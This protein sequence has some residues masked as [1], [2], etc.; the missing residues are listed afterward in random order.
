MP[1]RNK[2]ISLFTLSCLLA[3]SSAVAQKK[4]IDSLRNL[5]DERKED[6]LQAKVLIKLSGAYTYVDTEEAKIFAEKALNLSQKLQYQAGIANAYRSIGT[7]YGETSNFDQ[8][9]KNYLQGLKVAENTQDPRIKA[10]IYN[11]MGTVYSRLDDFPQAKSYYQKALNI[12]QKIDD[13]N[14]I[15]TLFNNL[16][17]VYNSEYN[18]DSAVFS[19]QRAL[20]IFEKKNNL[21]GMTYALGSL[22][23]F[24]EG[25]GDMNK[26]LESQ[27]KVRE[28]ERQF[29]NK[30]GYVYTTISIAS[31]YLKIKNYNAAEQYFKEALE[32]SKEIG[33][34]ELLRNSYQYLSEYYSAVEDYKRSLKYYEQ[35]I[36]FK[37]SIFNKDKSELIAK[38]QADYEVEQNKKQLEIQKSKNREQ[39]LEIKAQQ[40]EI[41]QHQLRNTVLIVGI[42]SIVVFAF[43]LYR[44]NRQKQK[45]NRILAEKNQLIEDKNTNITDS[46]NYARR[47][48]SAVLPLTEEIGHYIPEHFI[49]WKPRDIVSG[50]FYWFAKTNPEPIYEEKMTFEGVHRVF[51]GVKGEKIIVAAVDSTGH[52]VP[53]AFMSMIGSRLLNEIVNEL[54]ITEA[55]EILNQLH[56]RVRKALKQEETQSHDGMDVGLVV[57]DKD[58]KLMQF[59]GAK[60]PM[61]M[62]Q[63]PK[64]WQE[65]K[66]AKPEESG[67]ALQVVK[68]DV[69]S[70]GGFQLI[71]DVAFK[72]KIVSLSAKKYESTTFYLFSD[73]YQDQFGGIKGRKF[74]VKRFRKLLFEISSKPM[75][76]Q[77]KMLED[78]LEEWMSG[79]DQ[80][81]DILVMG[82]RM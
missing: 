29:G 73:G 41:E 48:Q 82:F 35:Y 24:Y 67:L 50:D 55:D 66:S 77:K 28:L 47:I 23:V 12:Y 46:I 15:A 81:D 49:L 32:L 38:I 25:I 56:L 34:A 22:G 13:Q 7:V 10:N 65:E 5:L 44:N 64:D 43:F 11:N 60:N 14:L 63:I 75:D 61:Y 69:M 37:D 20:S 27:N 72:K 36:N 80:V 53:G 8:A 40:S 58:K 70:I 52:G 33:S 54:G 57:I 16:G 4:V 62:V 51:K 71:E 59:A 76:V 30:S 18:T 39:Q 9:I 21:Q 42:L 31:I 19:Y 2:I 6:T 26:A 68:G 17:H 45:T 74:M 1:I 78:T 3:F 79:H